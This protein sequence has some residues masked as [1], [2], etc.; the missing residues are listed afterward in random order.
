[1]ACSRS[2]LAL[3]RNNCRKLPH[4][5]PFQND[6]SLIAKEKPLKRGAPAGVLRACLPAGA[7]P[8]MESDGCGW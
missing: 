3:A 4:C 5:G 8:W 7:L 1:V 6:K 2:N